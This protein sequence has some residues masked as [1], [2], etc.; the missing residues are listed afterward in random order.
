[1]SKDRTEILKRLPTD[2]YKKLYEAIKSGEPFDET[3]EAYDDAISQVWLV[4]EQLIQDERKE[5]V[6][7]YKKT[8]GKVFRKECP[9]CHS[10]EYSE[11]QFGYSCQ[12][13]FRAAVSLTKGGN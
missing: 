3:W 5:A 9:A 11:N 12:N 1:M 7:E 2:I 8:Q 10:K 13:C 6:E 4:V